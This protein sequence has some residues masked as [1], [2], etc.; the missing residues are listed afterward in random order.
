M[1]NFTF[2]ELMAGIGILLRAGKDRD[3]RTDLNELWNH[4]E[5]RPFFKA[6]MSYK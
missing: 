6:C 1:A 4:K 3:N 5:G 2:D